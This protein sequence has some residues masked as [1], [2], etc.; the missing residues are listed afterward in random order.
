LFWVRQPS[1]AVAWRDLRKNYQTA[2]GA[3]TLGGR[4]GVSRITEESPHAR[5]HSMPAPP[6]FIHPLGDFP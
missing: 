6:R 4:L 1:S 2:S 3:V 5:E